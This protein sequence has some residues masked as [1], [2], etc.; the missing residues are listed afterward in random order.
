MEEVSVGAVPVSTHF[1]GRI[2]TQFFKDAPGAAR[3]TILQWVFPEPFE[4][5]E[6][7]HASTLSPH[8]SRSTDGS[9]HLFPARPGIS[10]ATEKTR[11]KQNMWLLLQSWREY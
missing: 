11:H 7:N 4:L 1:H 10:A 9:K 2:Q 8:A 6:T 5:R 3:N